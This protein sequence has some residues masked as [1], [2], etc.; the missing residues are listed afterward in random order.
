MAIS[1]GIQERPSAVGVVPLEVADF[2]PDTLVEFWRRN[3]G[4]WSRFG[5][6]DRGQ[7]H[8]LAGHRVDEYDRPVRLLA[9][10]QTDCVVVRAYVE[11]HIPS[12]DV[13]FNLPLLNLGND[14]RANIG[15]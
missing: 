1:V 15:R 5:G 2:V 13:G 14:P 9:D 3:S 12:G 4:L 7:A 10:V 6:R 8:R 11:T